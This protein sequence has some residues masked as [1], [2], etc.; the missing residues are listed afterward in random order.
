M[1]YAIY[2]QGEI[3]HVR[4]SLIAIKRENQRAN[5][6]WNASCRAQRYY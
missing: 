4:S 3:R 1:V 2:L 5:V 6:G